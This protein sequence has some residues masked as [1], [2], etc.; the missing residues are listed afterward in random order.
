MQ[1]FPS[2]PYSQRELCTHKGHLLFH[3]YLLVSGIMP[4]SSAKVVHGQQRARE[5]VGVSE[6]ADGRKDSERCSC[7]LGTTGD[8]LTA[9]VA[10]VCIPTHP[11]TVM[12][13]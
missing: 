10:M 9:R 11:Q 6:C 12:G 13:F 5:E 8:R 1:L 4:T 7:I 3:T 2:C